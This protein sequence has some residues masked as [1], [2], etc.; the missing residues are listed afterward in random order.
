MAWRFFQSP[1]LLALLLLL[2][3]SGCCSSNSSRLVPSSQSRSF[4]DQINANNE[5]GK[6]SSS[7][8]TADGSVYGPAAASN[9]RRADSGRSSGAE[10]TGSLRDVLESRKA[11]RNLECRPD[12]CYRMQA[13]S[14]ASAGSSSP[15]GT[16]VCG[17]D[18]KTYD[19]RCM[20]Q[21][22][23]RC[24]G[25]KVR[26]R[27][28]GACGVPLPGDGTASAASASA[29]GTRAGRRRLGSG[30]GR[31]QEMR[32]AALEK[33]STGRQV[34]YVPQCSRRGKFRRVQCNYQLKYC[35]CVRRRSGKPLPGSGVQ[36][37]RRPSCRNGRR[38]RRKKQRRRQQQQKADQQADGNKRHNRRRGRRRKGGGRGS[39]RKNRCSSRQ[40]AHFNR[41]ILKQFEIEFNASITYRTGGLL[42][43]RREIGSLPTRVAAVEQ[44][45]Q[46]QPERRS[47][48]W[49]FT[50]LDLD[51][52]GQLN[53]RETK[54]L[55]KV[56]RANIKPKGCARRFFRTCDLNANKQLE[57]AE[58]ILCFGLEN[59]TPV[60]VISAPPAA[61]GTAPRSSQGGVAA[62][63]VAAATA[64]SAE[65]PGRSSSSQAA[66]GGQPLAA[67]GGSKGS[68]MELVSRRRRRKRPRKARPFAH[69]S[70]PL[71]RE[72]ALEKNRQLSRQRAATMASVAASSISRVFVP[73]CSADG[74]YA[75]R[76]CH[77][78]GAPTTSLLCFCMDPD[79]G[80]VLKGGTGSG[81]TLDCESAHIRARATQSAGFRGCS[82]PLLRE[83]A[84]Q[85][86]ALMVQETRDAWR[87]EDAHL[88]VEARSLKLRFQ[89]ADVSRDG[90][91]DRKEQRW[92]RREIKAHWKARRRGDSNGAEGTSDASSRRRRK[93]E[94]RRTRKCAVNFLRF[95]NA[96]GDQFV[97]LGE[98][99]ACLRLPTS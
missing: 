28:L 99:Q 45:M 76:Q 55:R 89:R 29:G 52:D 4:W 21:F 82:Q 93:P 62:P 23:R 92:W 88:S 51:G 32:L 7:T 34:I 84:S 20:L 47:A 85:L 10:S 68:L 37:P 60:T 49:K 26:V 80:R 48:E 6:S 19:S 77:T 27:H 57:R 44:S 1:L 71:A 5:Q 16:Q 15:A 97:T 50:Q 79:S 72:E 81:A 30:R 9:T 46:Q 73:E 3:S 56:T 13:S 8:R 98:L 59:S 39:G 33:S 95:C 96:N 78:A 54:A 25:Q 58:W 65:W 22:L 17:T 43:P 40:R 63:L 74:K 11:R 2:I 12:F 38:R 53:Y 86:T 61:A 36:L 91:L 42:K 94:L 69:K 18:G 35:F 75:K 14:A 64:V 41:N 87:P 67:G 24:H 66:S 90:Q 83:F 70:C 31:C